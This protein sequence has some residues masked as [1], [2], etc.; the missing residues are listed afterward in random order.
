MN[1]EEQ[2]LSARST[3]E[4]PSPANTVEQNVSGLSPLAHQSSSL[5]DYADQPPSARSIALRAS[6]RVRTPNQS[7]RPL[8]SAVSLDA[9]VDNQKDFRYIRAT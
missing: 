9:P 6:L 4:R 1:S 8:S 3:A 2:P 7:Q 5:S